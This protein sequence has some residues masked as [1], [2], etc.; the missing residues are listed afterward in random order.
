MFFTRKPKT[1]LKNFAST[2]TVTFVL[3]VSDKK[4]IVL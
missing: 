1:E 2:K 3:A 4:K